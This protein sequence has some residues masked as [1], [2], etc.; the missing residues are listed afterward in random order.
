MLTNK[1]VGVTALSSS[2]SLFPF[3]FFPPFLFSLGDSSPL[4]PVFFR[5]S[6][7]LSIVLAIGVSGGVHHCHGNALGNRSASL[8]HQ[9]LEKPR[10]V[11]RDPL[12]SVH[13]VFMGKTRNERSDHFKVVYRRSCQDTCPRQFNEVDLSAVK[14]RCTFM[15]NVL[16]VPKEFST[17]VIL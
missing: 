6:R 7:R 4:F 8:C 2:A 5:N 12:N 11:T 1:P 9:T 3:F 17:H 15:L 13:P 16:I 14:S 10:G